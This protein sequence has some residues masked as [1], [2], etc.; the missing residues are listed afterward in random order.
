MKITL[1][2][3]R[4][5][6]QKELELG[7]EGLTLLSG[8]SG[9]G[10]STILMAI[11]F[12]LFGVG[13]KISSKEGKTKVI[14]EIKDFK[15]ERTKRPNRLI[16]KNSTGEWL[17]DVAQSII[18]N[19]FGSHFDVSCYLNQQGENSFVKMSPVDKLSFLEKFSINDFD[20]Q[21]LKK[22]YMKNL[23]IATS[24]LCITIISKPLY[25][26][27]IRKASID[28][29]VALWVLPKCVL[30][31]KTLKLYFFNKLE[32]FFTPVQKWGGLCLNY[33]MFISN[34]MK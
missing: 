24:L 17:D 11:Y 14:L 20:I 30:E 7:E 27:A 25:F 15:I 12:A 22:K 5:W 32:M 21:S 10:K 2:N 16:V 4:C 8:Q 29:W 23:I 3:F 9:T 33:Y 6:E 34:L 28:K 26:R 1:K 18:N 19:E 13:K 31:Q